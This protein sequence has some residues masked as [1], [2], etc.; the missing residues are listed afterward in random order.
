MEKVVTCTH[1]ARTASA[2]SRSS[3]MRDPCPKAYWRNMTGTHSP[4][5]LPTAAYSYFGKM[6]I[7]SSFPGPAMSLSDSGAYRLWPRMAI[8]PPPRRESLETST[9]TAVSSKCRLLIPSWRSRGTPSGLSL[10][11]GPPH[12]QAKSDAVHKIWKSPWACCQLGPYHSL[13]PAACPGPA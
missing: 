9:I 5:E 6:I 4:G 11:R 12:A 7:I 13:L 3:R 8:H 2:A 1:A 10:T